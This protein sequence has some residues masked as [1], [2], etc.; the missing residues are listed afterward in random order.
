MT[1]KMLTKNDR[2]TI[3]TKMI[4]PSKTEILYFLN[5]CR[6][7][8]YT[9]FSVEQGLGIIEQWSCNVPKYMEEFLEWVEP[10]ILGYGVN[11]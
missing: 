2:V 11:D 8:H 5:F 10:M 3:T 6:G 7:M 1:V 4:N 9:E